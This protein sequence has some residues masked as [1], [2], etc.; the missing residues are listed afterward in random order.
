MTRDEDQIIKATLSAFGPDEGVTFAQDTWAKLHQA[1]SA[2]VAKPAPVQ[3]PVGEVQ[4]HKQRQFDDDGCVIGSYSKKTVTSGVYKLPH[5]TKLYTAPP[6]APVQPDR[7]GMTYYRNDACTA[8]DAHASDC[9][10]WTPAQPAPVQ[11]TCN[12]RWDGEVQVQQC[13]LHEAHVDAIHEWAE[14]AKAAE[15][16][17]KA[18]PAPT[19]QEP[20]AVTYKEVADTMNE[21]WGGTLEQV[22]IAM[23]LANKKL[24][25]TPPAAPVPTSW[26]EMVTANL[27]REGINKHKARELAEHF[28]GLAQ[29]QWVGLTDEEIIK[30][31]PG[32]IYDCLN[33]PWDCGVGDGDTL[34]SIKK[35]VLRIARAIEAKL[36]EKNND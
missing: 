21:L 5:G 15:A 11:Q 16:K 4:E 27:V 25:T 24:Y 34:R 9:I 10:C 6:A 3:E 36:K 30:A 7:T 12:C 26:M 18:Q 29:R 33:D 20:V 28:Y 1:M 2:V 22:Q 14:R 13:T 17:L 31:M 8:K 23:E 32:G 35:D 19:V